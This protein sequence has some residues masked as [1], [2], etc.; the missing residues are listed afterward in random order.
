VLKPPSC[1]CCCS[2]SCLDCADWPVLRLLLPLAP[3]V[4]RVM[5]LR[6]GREAVLSE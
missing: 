6:T 3:D 1:C 5:L 2:G 4:L